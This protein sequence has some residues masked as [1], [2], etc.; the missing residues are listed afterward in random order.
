MNLPVSKQVPEENNAVDWLA[1]ARLVIFIIALFALGFYF[2]G[3]IFYYH[4]VLI[5][6]NQN[7]SGSDLTNHQLQQIMNLLQLPMEFYAALNVILMGILG[8]AYVTVAI[9][10]LWFKPNDRMA[11]FTAL[12]LVLFGTGFPP[13]IEAFAQANPQFKALVDAWTLVGFTSLFILYYVFPDGRFVPRWTHDRG[14][15]LGGPKCDST[16]WPSSPLFCLTTQNPGGQF[17]RLINLGTFIFAQVYRYQMV[18][19]PVQRLQTKWVVVGLVT[20]IFGFVIPW[21]ARLFWPQ[22]TGPTPLGYWPMFSHFDLLY[23]FL[24]DTH[25]HLC[26]YQQVPPLEYRPAAAAH[27]D[28]FAAHAQPGRNLPG[29]GCRTT[30]SAGEDLGGR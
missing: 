25:H 27:S 21:I 24:A 18:S 14:S 11:V 8:L 26:S 22:L 13:V 15:F 2:G 30:G 4:N 1:I 7:L 19:D 12:V 3:L 10:M 6:N 5:P 28:L 23:E 20:A 9:L 16:Y 29:G 17:S